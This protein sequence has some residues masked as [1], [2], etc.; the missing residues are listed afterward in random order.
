MDSG[1]NHSGHTGSVGLDAP[2]ERPNG[3]IGLSVAVS[4]SDTVWFHSLLA[5]ITTGMVPLTDP[6]LPGYAELERPLSQGA[7]KQLGGIEASSSCL[8]MSPPPT[9]CIL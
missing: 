1:L 8:R 2:R 3:I 5:Y 6:P 9:I 4:T 7:W